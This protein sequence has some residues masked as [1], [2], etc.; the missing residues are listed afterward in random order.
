MALTDTYEPYV[1]KIIEDNTSY[2]TVDF[3]YQVGISIVSPSGPTNPQSITSLRTYLDLY[4]NGG[5]ISKNNHISFLSG[6]KLL[7]A[8]L[9]LIICR[10]SSG[11]ILRG[12][13]NLGDEYYSDGVNIYNNIFEIPIKNED[14]FLGSWISINNKK[15]YRTQDN[16]DTYFEELGKKLKLVIYTDKI[17]ITSTDSIQFSNHYKILDTNNLDNILLT[18]GR[19]LNRDNILSYNGISL[20]NQGVSSFNFEYPYTGLQLITYEQKDTLLDYE[21]AIAYLET[22]ETNYFIQKPLVSMR[23]ECKVT[24]PSG[25]T[26]EENKTN[27]QVAGQEVIFTINNEEELENGSLIL[28]DNGTKYY[29]GSYKADLDKDLIATEVNSKFSGN[30]LLAILKI[31]KDKTNK[32]PENSIV[33]YREGL[34]LEEGQVFIYN[35]KYYNTEFAFYSGETPNNENIKEINKTNFKLQSYTKN[36]LIE[37]DSQIYKILTDV[38]VNVKQIVPKNATDETKYNVGEIVKK[39]DSYYEVTKQFTYDDGVTDITQYALKLTITEFNIKNTY[40]SN[41]YITFQSNIYKILSSF[42]FNIQE[43]NKHE[44]EEVLI[45]ETE[46]PFTIELDKNLLTS[47]LWNAQSITPSTETKTTYV[48]ENPKLTELKISQYLLDT[49]T[50]TT[51]YCGDK[52]FGEKLVNIGGKMT[53]TD[54]ISGVV[55]QWTANSIGNSIYENN[56]FKVFATQKLTEIKYHFDQYDFTSSYQFKSFDDCLFGVLLNFPTD[57]AD[58]YFT[59]QNNFED[60]DDID[61]KFYFNNKDPLSYTFSMLEEKLNGYGINISYNVIE[62]D[63]F[64]IQKFSG[65]QRLSSFTSQFFPSVKMNPSAFDI[66]MAYD[67]IGAKEEY[68]YNLLYD[69]CNTNV[70]VTQKLIALSNKLLTFTPLSAPIGTSVLDTID[71]IKNW[72]SSIGITTCY[73]WFCPDTFKMS[74]GEFTQEFPASL[75]YMLQLNT[76]RLQNKEFTPIYG[77]VNGFSYKPLNPFENKEDRE[78]LLGMRINTIKYNPQ[79][80]NYMFNNNITMQPN[81]SYMSDE[82]VVRMISRATQIGYMVLENYDVAVNNFLTRKQV[83]DAVTTAI[84]NEIPKNAYIEKRVI[85]DDT[86]NPPSIID[87]EKLVCEVEIMPNRYS[88]YRKIIGRPI[89]LNK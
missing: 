84:D 19:S 22:L 64:K 25:V 86:N 49:N 58:I 42:T 62:N 29:I 28:N 61:L 31:L 83:S 39:D 89:Q 53:I 14:A 51:Y 37:L 47:Y 50:N 17:I 38:V 87:A 46:E 63:Y 48:V 34:N 56:T 1:E 75:I 59:Y 12:I 33:D 18:L 55:N 79:N 54:F 36:N 68:Q 74:F 2:P 32:I 52:P 69:N 71:K 30:Y 66:A 77:T 88:K 16:F 21:Y 3:N 85:C 6:Y 70:V 80:K 57:G 26:V 44:L 82:Y 11:S 13:T 9:P 4:N 73:Q 65:N 5:I 23:G 8:G 72:K 40:S 81:K 10:A 76:N 24:L 45:G 67:K 15:E 41:Q 35:T 20:Y 78:E 27:L 60:E 7:E 43:L